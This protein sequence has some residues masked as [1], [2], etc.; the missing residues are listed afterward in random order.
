MVKNSTIISKKI[1]L[2]DLVGFLIYLHE[3]TPKYDDDADELITL[4]IFIDRISGVIR[5]G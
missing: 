3:S 2:K 1:F 5:Y 4:L